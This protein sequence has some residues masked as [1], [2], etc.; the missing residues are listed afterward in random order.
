MNQRQFWKNSF[1][2]CTVY[3]F[4]LLTNG[5]YA[6][7]EINHPGFPTFAI[8]T[9]K[10]PVYATL[11]GGFT[12]YPEKEKN[13][14][15]SFFRGLKHFSSVASGTSY[16][17]IKF[18]DKVLKFSELKNI[19]SE[20]NIEDS[21]VT[22]SGQIPVADV[23]IFMVLRNKK[24]RDG[25]FFVTYSAVNRTNR[26]IDIG[27]RSLVD[28]GTEAS[29]G[30]PLKIATDNTQEKEIYSNEYKFTPFKSGYWETY[31]NDS[32]SVIG[33]RNHLTG[34]DNSPPD[35]IAFVNWERAFATDWNYFTNKNIT[36]SL[37]SAVLIWWNPQPVKQGE[38][39]DITTEYEIKK[40][41][42]GIS[43]ELID[44]DTGSGRIHLRATNNTNL[45]QEI[46]YQLDAGS[47]AFLSLNH[48]NPL[49]FT[50]DKDSSLDK[51]ISITL[52]GKGNV[53][54][55]VKEKFG[56]MVTNHN[57]PVR[58][59]QE[60][61]DQSPKFWKSSKYPIIYNSDKDG[62]KLKGVVRAKD[63]G[64]KLGETDLI[65][66]KSVQNSFVYL[67]EVDLR[68][69]SGEVFVEIFKQ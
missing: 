6:V 35:Q 37:D 60:N 44:P 20:W 36:T 46:S 68:E 62:L 33:I 50:L 69:F 52:H 38:R 41:K 24:N 3:L 19:K 17:S 1:I 9:G 45:P 10:T 32:D 14:A 13:K 16:L 53:N 64:R 67:G 28:I 21:S 30:I 48:D 47:N 26:I 65:S 34:F 66:V 22:I 7:E 59:T 42:D 25:S 23:D 56:Q 63:T 15:E 54:L 11:S 40:R 51:I 5:S 55:N 4:L 12:F 18:E 2:H 39:R 43:F 27:F 29:D 57:L 8:Y 31:E 61:R 49:K 58:L